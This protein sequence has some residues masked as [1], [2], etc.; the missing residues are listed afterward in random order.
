MM[1]LLIPPDP[2][3]ASGSCDSSSDSE[4]GI[5]MG[6]CIWQLPPNGPVLLKLYAEKINHVEKSF[7]VKFPSKRQTLP[8]K[9]LA[10]FFFLLSLFFRGKGNTI[11][12]TQYAGMDKNNNTTSEKKEKRNRRASARTL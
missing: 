5:G 9:L 2:L 10:N 7:C 11:H 12:D 8:P 4:C 6:P 3:S 1:G